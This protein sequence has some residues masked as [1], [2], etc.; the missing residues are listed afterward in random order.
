MR[1]ETVAVHAG[2]DRDPVTRAVSPPIHLSTNYELG[3]GSEQI[4][5]YIYGRNANPTQDRLESALAALEGGEAALAFGSGVAAGA[6]LLQAIPPGSH[7][8]FPD[9]VYYVYRQMAVEYLPRWGMESTIV[10][11]SDLAALAAAV[12]PTTRLLW[13]ETPSN[14][15]LKVTDLAAVSEIARRA[16]ALSLVDNTFATPILQRPIERGFDLVLHSTTKYMGGHG[17]V[18][19]GAVVFRR[20][21]AL[22]EA[23]RHVRDVQG[24]VASPFSSWLVL[25]GL[26]SLPCRVERHS[27]NAME[28]ARFLA[29]RSGVRGVHYP[30]LP[31]DPGHAVAARQMSAFGG[32]LSFHV[33]DGR[34]AAV[35]ATSRTRLFVNATSLGGPE[36]LIEH[37]FSSEGQ[38]SKTPDDLLRL[39]VGLESAQDLIEDLDQAL[40]R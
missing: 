2:A 5:G 33:D 16:G 36:S 14:P 37:R 3:P 9:D 25:R 26:R 27:S 21:D 17:D 34:E 13:A 31:G 30:G 12:R 38:G 1:I 39:S 4:G 32:M 6:A 11:M 29:A 24:A 10:D 19:G 23:T 40:E 18:Q 15:L 20:R 28:V 7:V 8:I 22:F 35:R